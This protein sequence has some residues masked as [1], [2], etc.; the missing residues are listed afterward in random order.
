[1]GAQTSLQP[2]RK[3]VV[4]ALD[5]IRRMVRTLRTSATDIERSTGLSAAQT[6]V[7]QLLA[8]EPAES[9]NDLAAR[10]LTDQSSVS[11]VVSR[12]EQKGLVARG[13]SPT[14][15]RRTRVTIT[16]AG[17]ARLVGKPVTVQARL[18]R[19]LEK[20]TPSAL[21]QLGEHLTQV[22]ALMGAAHEPPSLF[23]EE[24]DS[25]STS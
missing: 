15:A 8:E 21:M 1:M 10:T 18:I 12:L 20:L 2:D 22:T 17:R 7:L 4:A 16:D 11:V 14:D 3:D 25:A 9:M 19:A 6:F 24:D 13:Q 23:F 5:A